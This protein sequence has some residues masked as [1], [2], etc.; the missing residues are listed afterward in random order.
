M[1]LT[2]IDNVR[3]LL[4]SSPAMLSFGLERSSELY[5]RLILLLVQ[6][7]FGFVGLFSSSP[8]WRC[9][10]LVFVGGVA[11]C[12]RNFWR[13]VAIFGG[14]VYLYCYMMVVIFNKGK[15]RHLSHQ[16]H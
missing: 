15:I 11:A 4:A 1:C 8:F 16:S 13:E 12:G 2:A 9:G 14:R 3:S 10:C 5:E 6:N 7:G